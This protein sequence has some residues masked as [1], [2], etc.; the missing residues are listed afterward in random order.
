MELA[1]DLSRR[2]FFLLEQRNDRVEKSCRRGGSIPRARQ[3]KRPPGLFVFEILV[4]IATLASCWLRG[5]FYSNEFVSRRERGE[6]FRECSC[7]V[8]L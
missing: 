7:S 1:E 8:N 3:S 2:V 4:L 5:F 6:G